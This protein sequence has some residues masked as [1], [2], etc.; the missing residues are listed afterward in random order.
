MLYYL[1]RQDDGGHQGRLRR[2]VHRPR[3]ALSGP[4]VR[5]RLPVRRRHVRQ[6]QHGRVRLRQ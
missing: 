5:G 6:G 4:R 1:P 2:K 3:R